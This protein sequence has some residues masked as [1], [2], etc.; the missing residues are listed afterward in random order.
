VRDGVDVYVDAHDEH[1]GMKMSEVMCVMV[2]MC[3]C[4]RMMSMGMMRVRMRMRAR[5]TWMR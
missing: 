4:M 2:W 3:M 1:E 5:M